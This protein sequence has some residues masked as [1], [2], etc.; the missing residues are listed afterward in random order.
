[1]GKIKDSLQEYTH[2]SMLYKLNIDKSKLDE[3]EKS[4][5]EENKIDTASEFSDTGSDLGVD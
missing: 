3:V 2:S 4:D 1:M 5:K